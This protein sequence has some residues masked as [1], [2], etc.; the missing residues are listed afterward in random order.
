MHFTSGLCNNAKFRINITE[1]G[2]GRDDTNTL[3]SAVTSERRQRERWWMNELRTIY[4]YGLNIRV[5]ADDHT[6]E[7]RNLISYNNFNVLPSKRPK[8]R[9]RY[10]CKRYIKRVNNIN[11]IENTVNYLKMLTSESLPVVFKKGRTCIFGLPKCV[12]SQVSDKFE[13]TLKDIPSGH[14]QQYDIICDL[15]KFRKNSRLNTCGTNKMRRNKSTFINI[16]FVNKGIEMVNLSRIFH[17]SEVK[18]A[19]PFRSNKDRQ[20]HIPTVSYT[21]PPPIRSKILNYKETLKEFGAEATQ[22]DDIFPSFECNTSPFK[23]LYHGHVITGDL[24]LIKNERLRKLIS[25]GTGYRENIPIN[26]IETE[27]QIFIALDT[28]IKTISERE[29]IAIEKFREFK[30]KVKDKVKIEVN[31]N[32][33]RYKRAK[34]AVPVLK[35]PGAAKELKR[36]HNEYVL[37]S[38]DKASKNVGIICKRF[39]LESIYKELHNIDPNNQI[40][41][42]RD[43]DPERAIREH[44]V[45][46]KS[47][48]MKDIDLEGFNELPFIY[49]TPKFHKNPIKFRPIVASRSCSTKPLANAISKALQKI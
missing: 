35:D 31:L 30:I 38:V 42:L 26:W 33:Q 6:H 34:N 9:G 7:N 22:S 46:S 13:A 44:H 37:T 41:Q 1:K 14:T 17:L 28:L 24:S 39:Y 49:F 16:H 32:K 48:G 45:F 18:N 12:I 43:I 20:M 5:G 23:D 15:I 8:K 36:L 4:P 2:N 3:D 19:L 47:I 25:K 29:H 11:D 21:Y 27:K 10:R 40:Y